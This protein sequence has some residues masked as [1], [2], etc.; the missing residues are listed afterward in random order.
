MAVIKKH[1]EV[2]TDEVTRIKKNIDIIHDSHMSNSKKRE[3]YLDFDKE[4]IEVLS[5]I[6]KIE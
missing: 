6:T 4:L 3:A 2:I 1:I 5:L